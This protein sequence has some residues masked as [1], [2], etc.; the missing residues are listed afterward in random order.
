MSSE[1]FT[2]WLTY[3]RAEPFGYEVD[4]YRF[5]TSVAAIVNQVAATIPQQPGHTRK[6]KQATDYYPETIKQKPASSLPPRIK[7]ELARRRKLN[8][9]KR[10]NSR[11]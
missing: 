6:Q 2:D 11:N 1:E 7:A 5:G 3:Y 8:N 9:G 10:G 4:N